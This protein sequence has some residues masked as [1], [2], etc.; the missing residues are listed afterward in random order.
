[1][2]TLQS[3]TNYQPKSSSQVFETRTET[4][5]I[6]SPPPAERTDSRDL[7]QPGGGDWQ[8]DATGFF[9]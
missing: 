4:L 2:K 9:A 8:S 1:M 3:M 6:L 5:A 7:V